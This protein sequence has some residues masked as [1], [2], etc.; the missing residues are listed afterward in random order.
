MME[1]RRRRSLRWASSVGNSSGR[2]EGSSTIEA[3][4]TARQAASGRRAHQR[5]SV[6]GWPCRMDFSRADSL[7]MASRGRSTSMSFLR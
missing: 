3:K 5:C 6:E 4:R 2:A 7:L 1:W